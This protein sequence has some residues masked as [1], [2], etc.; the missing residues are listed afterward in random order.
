M[1]V[2]RTALKTVSRDFPGGLVVK[3]SHYNA[4]GIGSIPGQGTKISQCLTAKKQTKKNQKQ[5][6]NKFNKDLKW[7]ISKNLLKK[8]INKSGNR[9]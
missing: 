1:F 6:H 9:F 7:S 4:V 5:Y 8:K 2:Q 3:M